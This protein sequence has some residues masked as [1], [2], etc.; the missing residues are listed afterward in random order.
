MECYVPVEANSMVEEL[1]LL[2]N[3][4]VAK[5]VLDAFPQSALLRRHPHPQARDFAPLRA[6]L[7]AHGLQLDLGS[8]T[9]FANSLDACEKE[10]EPYFNLL[11][12]YMAV[13]A[14][15]A[16]EYVCAGEVE[17]AGES[18]EHYGLASPVYTH[19]TSPIRRYA[20]QL[21]HRMLAAA[22]GWD[23]PTPALSD[24]AAVAT[25][26][27]TLNERHAAA[28]EAERASVALYSLLFF[29]NRT[30]VEDGYLTLVRPNGVGVL[31]PRY[32]LD[33]W[34]HNGRMGAS[35]LEW[36]VPEGVLRG[37][38]GLTLKAM[39]KVRVRIGVD[40]S[41]LHAALQMELLDANGQPLIQP[42]LSPKAEGRVQAQADEKEAGTSSRPAKERRLQK[43][44]ADKEPAPKPKRKRSEQQQADPKLEQQQ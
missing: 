22:I 14:M 15:P 17:A 34:I 38:G 26:A 5:T 27:R 20:D 10:G 32:G 42:F 25:L 44:A 8:T 16:A 2:A 29:R 12:R 4:T 39:D 13:R 1:M 40:T 7:K 21:V 19:F 35:P 6:A 18:Y 37:E 24:G 43:R 30:V 3:I 31:V 41:R 9:A 11:A 28:K 33:G 36:I 23:A